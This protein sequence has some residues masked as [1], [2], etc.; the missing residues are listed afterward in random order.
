MKRGN[1]EETEAKDNLEEIVNMFAT[2]EFL[3]TKAQQ[4]VSCNI[5]LVF[6]EQ[7]NNNLVMWPY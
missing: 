3:L 6:S 5:M 1:L 2:E 7:Y 4:E